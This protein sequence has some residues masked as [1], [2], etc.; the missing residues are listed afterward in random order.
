MRKV[1][2][3]GVQMDF[4]ASER[5]VNMGPAAIRHAHL[6]R[7]MKLLNIDYRDRGDIIPL[8]DGASLPGLNH[9]EQIVDANRKLFQE[10]SVSI[11]DDRMP[12]VLGGDHAIAAGSI[13]AIAKS[14]GEIGLIW[15]DAHGDFNDAVSS[16]TGNM[17]GMPFSAVCGKGPKEMEI[18]EGHFVAPKKAVQIAGR[19]IDVAERIRLKE[20][21]VTVFSISDIDRMGIA[22]VIEKAIAIAS[23]Q[24]NGIH[25]SYDMDSVTPDEAPG[26][27][28]PVHSGLT[29]REAFLLMEMLHGCNKVCSMDMVEVN[30]ILDTHNKTG[31][32]A[33]ELILSLL[34]KTVY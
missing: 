34:G 30:P 27:G 23:D 1:D 26:V 31:N 20:S 3:I 25:V 24:T 7:K 28:T 19:D 4:G 13:Q 32:L 11:K 15:V 16:P 17:H 33:C 18:A 10:V 2:I 6:L 22:T 29:V 5:G 8:Q 9:C 14:L 12:I 21:G